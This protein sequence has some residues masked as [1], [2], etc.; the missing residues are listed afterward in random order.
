VSN[1]RDQRPCLFCGDLTRSIYQ[2]CQAHYSLLA[3][4]YRYVRSLALDGPTATDL[5]SR[6]AERE[7][8]PSREG[9]ED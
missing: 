3:E 8:M 1:R 7:A 4:D 6:A 2:V 9:T 5:H